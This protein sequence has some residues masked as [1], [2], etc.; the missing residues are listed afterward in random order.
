MDTVVRGRG[1]DRLKYLDLEGRW[2]LNGRKSI[3]F[4]SQAFRHLESLNDATVPLKDI[5]DQPLNAIG[6]VGWKRSTV[7]PVKAKK[8]PRF[9]APPVVVA[10]EVPPSP[11]EAMPHRSY[12]YG[13]A[14]EKRRLS[15]SSARSRSAS[16]RPVSPYP[17]YDKY[18]KYH[19]KDSISSLG[20]GRIDPGY[21]SGAPSPQPMQDEEGWVPP[22]RTQA[23]SP[24]PGQ[25]ARKLYDNEY[26][27]G[28]LQRANQQKDGL[29]VN[30]KYGQVG[31]KYHHSSGSIGSAGSSGGSEQNS[32]VTQRSRDEVV[33]IQY[34]MRAGGQRTN[35][36]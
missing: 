26:D 3:P 6:M 2:V 23:L 18:A 25:H 19:R 29:Q 9:E 33:M 20:G 8:L 34:A 32:P 15:V 31:R 21:A 16:P 11:R 14:H 30:T 28:Y 36:H 24:R 7:E 13:A 1:S 17:E 4:I 35:R 27:P 10:E 22:H 5:T 12:G